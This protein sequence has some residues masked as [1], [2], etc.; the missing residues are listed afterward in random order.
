[1]VIFIC[2]AGMFEIVTPL[3]STFRFSLRAL[4][5]CFVLPFNLYRKTNLREFVL[6]NI[7]IIKAYTNDQMHFRTLLCTD[8]HLISN[9]NI[10]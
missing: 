7:L 9:F 4:Y 5:F 3:R 8:F 6:H 2:L 10:Y 1:M